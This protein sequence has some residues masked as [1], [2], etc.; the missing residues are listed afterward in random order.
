MKLCFFKKFSVQQIK[1]SNCIKANTFILLLNLLFTF[2]YYISCSDRLKCAF[3]ALKFCHSISL[4]ERD[5][6]WR[7]AF[8]KV[9][10]ECFGAFFLI[11]NCFILG[12]TVGVALPWELGELLIICFSYKHQASYIYPCV[13]YLGKQKQNKNILLCTFVFSVRIN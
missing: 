12:K 4:F 7:K 3:N 8:F 5:K 6:I 10:R 11:W 13:H 9:V 1:G 2:L